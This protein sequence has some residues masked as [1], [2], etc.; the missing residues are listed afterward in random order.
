M[1]HVQPF[2]TRRCATSPATASPPASAR[3]RAG[4]RTAA[5]RRIAIVGPTGV[6]KTAAV[7]RLA[8]ALGRGRPHR[9]AWSCVAP[10]LSEGEPHPLTARLGAIAGSEAERVLAYVGGNDLARVA[11]PVDAARALQRF[12]D[13]D[14]VLIDTPGVGI[15]NDERLEAIGCSL[16]GLEPH[17]VHAALPLA[18]ARPRG[19]RRHRRAVAPRRQPRAGDEDRRGALRRRAARP[20]QPLGR[21]RCPTWRCG[22]RIPGDIGSR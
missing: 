13:R 11:S 4:R 1:L 14:V 17:E 9:S 22:L 8:A 5:A 10:E 2:A 12:A 6:G 15:A 18:L 7:V 20:G 16:I 3:S 19:R 21:C